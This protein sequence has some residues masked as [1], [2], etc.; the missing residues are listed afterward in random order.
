[1]GEKKRKKDR[2]IMLSIEKLN[3]IKD[4]NNKLTIKLKEMKGNLPI[5][6]SIYNER[7]Y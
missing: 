2:E 3:Q 7:K 6:K 5:N 4:K 1:M